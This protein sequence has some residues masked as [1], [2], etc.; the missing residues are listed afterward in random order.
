MNINVASARWLGQP[1]VTI[2]T[3][4][5]RL[6]TV[7]GMG[8][9]IV[10]I[11]DKRMGRE[12]L[13]P[14]PNRPFRPAAYGA[15]FIEQDMSGWDEMY[16]TIDECLYP[17]AGEH[18]G[19]LLPDHGEVWAIPWTLVNG[20]ADEIRLEVTGRALPYRLT[21]TISF[22]EAAKLR[23]AYTV[24]NLS[25]QDLIGFWTA[26][27]QFVVDTETRI[28]LSPEVTTVLNVV[29]DSHWGEI[30]KA[31]AWREPVPHA[32]DAIY[33]DRVSLPTR[34]D[35]RKIY[36]PP[37]QA[38]SWAALHN[39]SDGSLLRLS[40]DAAVV[41]YFGIW[42]DEGTYTPLSTAALEPSTGYYD[43]LTTAL[44]N[45]RV[46]TVP[47]RGSLEWYLDVECGQAD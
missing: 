40:W 33:L 2:E 14:P 18:A 44:E 31:Y 32:G 7:P 9:K 23:F 39:L 43:S 15:V 45:K 22:I 6:I 37:E 5:V 8:A 12:W 25:D 38:I 19:K 35:C 34:R 42:V 46:P 20:K 21:R 10:S 3:E 24:E 16:P 28:V 30:G 47:A 13:L 4:Q 11:F 26:H 29:G 27:P 1:A 17:L 41:P 36:L